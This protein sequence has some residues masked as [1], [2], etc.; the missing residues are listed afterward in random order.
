M[1]SVTAEGFAKPFDL[2]GQPYAVFGNRVPALRSFYL[3]YEPSH[4]YESGATDRHVNLIHLLAGGQSEDLN[5]NA[6]LEPA[7][8]PDGRLEVTIQDDGPEDEEFY[9]KVSH[10]LLDAPGARRFQIRDVGCVGE[11]VQRVPIPVTG[12]HGSNLFPPLIALVGFRLFFTGAR[13]HHLDRIG[14]WFEGQDLHI[15]LRDK[16]GDDTFGYLVDFVVIPTMSLKVDTGTETGSGPGGKKFPLP[17][18]SNRDFIL[19]GWEF[20][21]E[22]GDHEIRELGVLRGEDDVTVI[23]ADKNADDW[24]NWRIRYAQVGSRVLAPA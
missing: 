19:T 3:R 12:A 7:N 8:V 9:Y 21:F 23:Y 24:F 16:N 20:N 4:W 18:I 5:P 22:E 6:E 15:V 11:C 10:S 1:S 2:D 13:D 17:G 14:V